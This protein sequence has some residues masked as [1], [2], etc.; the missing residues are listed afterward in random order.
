[1]EE[2]VSESVAEILALIGSAIGSAVFTVGGLL[3]EQSSIQNVVAGQSAVGLW[4]MY[5]GAIALIVGLY[6]L[7]YQEC[8][9]RLM[10]YRRAS[11]PVVGE[12]NE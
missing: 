9:P 7:G 10:E 8:W 1:M 2:F 11:K 4:E 3:I 6:L 12:P 5:M